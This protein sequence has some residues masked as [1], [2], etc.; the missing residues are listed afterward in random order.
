[1]T[2]FRTVGGR[3]SFA[4]L[5]LVAGALAIVYL[6]VV[7]SLRRSL[8]DDRLDELEQNANTVAIQIASQ[9]RAEWPFTVLSSAPLMNARVTVLELEAPD[10]VQPVADSGVFRDIVDDP[11]A[12]QAARTFRIVRATV[13]RRDRSYAEVAVPLT[14]EG[15]VIL[16]SADLS[17]RLANIKVVERRLSIAALIAIAISMLVGYLAARVFARRIRRLERAVDRLARGEFD[18]PVVD[19]A[20][21]ELGRLAE[22]VDRM[23]RQLAGLDRARGEF[24]ANA[25]HE[26]RTPLFSLSGF[27]EL[28]SDEELDEETRREFV[29]TMR[30]Q[31]SRLTRLATDLLDLSRLDAG[32][33]RLD[34]AEL[35]LSL[36]A[37]ALVAEFGPVAQLEGRILEAEPDGE[38]AA[39]GD[40]E[41]V[42]QI[43]R[44]LIE[45]AIRHTPP[46]TRIAVRA[47]SDGIAGRLSVENDGPE[48][49]PEHARQIFERFYRVEGSRASGSGLGLAIAKELAELMGGRIQLDSGPGKTIFSLV[50]PAPAGARQQ[51]P[52]FT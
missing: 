43:G 50:L 7:P 2:P 38:V 12:L 27:L 17:D 37:A 52:V 14:A 46:G 49:P 4:S 34:A 16:L 28:L 29:Q 39:I 32:E 19:Q 18:E 45:N 51:A 25:S 20:A 36:L 47:G 9:P 35:D 6:I 48:I 31:V 1:M 22:A 30:E 5:L 33:V 8:V 24:I 13:A 10:S 21:D 15:P 40:E 3:L 23:R 26:L 41:R 42:L 44:L 11:V